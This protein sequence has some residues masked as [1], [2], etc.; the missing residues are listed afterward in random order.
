[1]NHWRRHAH[2][3]ITRP[4]RSDTPPSPSSFPPRSTPLTASLDN[5]LPPNRFPTLEASESSAQGGL[6]DSIKRIGS[7]F[8]VPNE[9]PGQ[10]YKFNWSLNGDGVTPL[11]KS[12]FRITKPLDL[13]VAGLA[14]PR[15]SPL[16]VRKANGRR[17]AIAKGMVSL[18]GGRL[19]GV[20]SLL[21]TFFLNRP[22]ESFRASSCY[23]FFR[24]TN[25][26]SR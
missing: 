12:A 5:S 1:M 4:P 23:G 17:G 18:R 13:K 6:P 11:K 7:A 14:Q 19:D 16:K 26:R 9:Y 10:D 25:N 21:Y 15:T 8:S 2:D 3:G 22:R 24:P 20:R